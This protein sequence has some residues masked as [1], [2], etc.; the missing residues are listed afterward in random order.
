VLATAQALHAAGIRDTR[1]EVIARGLQS[2]A[3]RV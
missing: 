1:L 3:L 2:E